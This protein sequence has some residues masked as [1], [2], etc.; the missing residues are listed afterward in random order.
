MTHCKHFSECKVRLGRNPESPYYKGDGQY[1]HSDCKYCYGYEE[2]VELER[3]QPLLKNV[4]LSEY[5]QLKGTVEYLKK[6]LQVINSDKKRGGVGS[7]KN[8]I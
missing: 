4:S 7:Y 8:I 2:S 6:Q 1:Y 5:Q 3:P